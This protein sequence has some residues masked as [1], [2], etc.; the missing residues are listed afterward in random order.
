M[1]LTLIVISQDIGSL[2]VSTLIVLYGSVDTRTFSRNGFIAKECILTYVLITET[3][4]IAKTEMFVEVESKTTANLKYTLQLLFSLFRS[5]HKRA[6]HRIRFIIF[7][8]RV[9]TDQQITVFAINPHRRT[10]LDDVFHLIKSGRIFRCP[11]TIY[12]RLAVI[13]T[14]VGL[15]AFIGIV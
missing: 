14:G 15:K 9:L 7:Q 3:D 8:Q 6:L 1:F 13:E 2:K 10:V 11:H 4:S 12:F 5:R